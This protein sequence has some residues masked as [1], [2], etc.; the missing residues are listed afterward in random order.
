MGTDHRVMAWFRNQW[1]KYHGFN[2]SVIT[3]NPVEEYG[4]KGREEATGRGVGSLTFK[5]SKRLGLEPPRTNIAIQ[6]FGNVGTHAAKYLYESEFPIVAVSD[7]T[8]TYYHPDGL[9]I[10]AILH[11]KIEHLSLIH[12]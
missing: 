7:I 10:A 11:H 6:G 2:P 4:A 1:E 9:D 3:G 8:G 5:L 12:I